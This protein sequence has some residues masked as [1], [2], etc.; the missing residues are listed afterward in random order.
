MRFDGFEWD[1][2]NSEKIT[3]HG[4]S[5]SQVEALLL[6]DLYVA[7]DP[8]HSMAE[9]RYWAIGQDGLGRYVFVVFTLRRYLGSLLI[10]PISARY[11]HRKE[12]RKYEEAISKNLQR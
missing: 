5:R 8:L 2:G 4:L 11:M 6:G 10:R 9:Q 3:Q 7:P 12:V 1:R